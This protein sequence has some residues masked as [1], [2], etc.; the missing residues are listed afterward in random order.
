MDMGNKVYLYNPYG[1]VYHEANEGIAEESLCGIPFGDDWKVVHSI[2]P[3]MV[4]CP[5]CRDIQEGEKSLI[6]KGYV[7]L[8]DGMY[9]KDGV[10]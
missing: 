5:E 6:G 4:V 1:V 2:H 10:R 8:A 3:G 7:P 9:K